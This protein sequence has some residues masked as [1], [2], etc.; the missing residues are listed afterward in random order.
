MKKLRKKQTKHICGLESQVNL[1]Q[2]TNVIIVLFSIY[3]P[4]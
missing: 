4:S 2:L 3:D 1:G